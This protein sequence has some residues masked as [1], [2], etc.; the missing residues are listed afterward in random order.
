MFYSHDKESHVALVLDEKENDV[1]V[2]E[3]QKDYFD[4]AM[5][6]I[7]LGRR[8]KEEFEE[9][10]MPLL[11]NIDEEELLKDDGAI[12][13]QATNIGYAFATEYLIKRTDKWPKDVVR[14]CLMLAAKEHYP[15]TFRVLVEN[16]KHIDEAFY[17]ELYKVTTTSQD[18]DLKAYKKKLLG[19]GWHIRKSYEIECED[20]GIRNIFNFASSSVITIV[21]LDGSNDVKYRDF[22]DF[23]TDGEIRIAYEK[24]CS[25]SDNPPKYSNKDQRSHRV[26]K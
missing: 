20:N 18:E 14:S 23:Q 12:L 5:N 22:K 7:A 1:E 2:T 24:L 8:L 15:N 6:V 11:E 21:N 17:A 25:F 9:E 16:T 3:N 10:L 26:I 13:K 19:K 4:E